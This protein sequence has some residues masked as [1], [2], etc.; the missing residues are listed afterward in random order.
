MGS[1]ATLISL[2]EYLNTSY[3]PDME[4]VDGELVRRNVGTP[5]HGWLQGIV[6]SY[7]RQFRE[8][9]RINAFV[10]ARLLV[11]STTGRH[12]IPDV[13]VLETP[14]R[15]GKVVL[16]VPVIVVEIKSPEDTFDDIVDLRP[17]HKRAWIFER[18]DLRLL[19]GSSVALSL[20][21][22]APIDFLFAEMFAELDEQD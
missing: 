14:H 7:F 6:V 17:D 22:G 3:E 13:M 9:H 21:R 12:R 5:R 18:G 8:S 1:P 10:D 15:M 20:S 11:D 19:P 2:D 4:F 16:D